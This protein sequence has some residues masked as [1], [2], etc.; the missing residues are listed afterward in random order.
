MIEAKL[1]FRYGVMG[2]GKTRDL[3]KNY[4]SYKED[5]KQVIIM[6]PLLDSK[7]DDKV[8]ARDNQSNKVDFLISKND[9]IYMIIAEY[10][11]E[12]NLDYILVDEAQFLEPAQ[13]EQLSNIVD[14]LEI[15]V[16]CYGLRED[17]QGKLFPGSKA[18]FENADSLEEL[19]TVCECGTKAIRNIRY[20]NGIL[21][22]SGD[23]VAIDGKDDVTYVS[24]CRKCE[25]KLIRRK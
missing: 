22:Y 21:T 15:P 16:I 7:G 19:K 2:A 10:L 20:V 14:Y 6:K 5:G 8:I 23:Q 13:I 17:F 3:Q 1:Y 12:N 24:V 18:L 4:Y 25:K 9:N 11:I